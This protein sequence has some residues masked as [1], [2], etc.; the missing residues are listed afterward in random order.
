MIPRRRKILAGLV[1]LAVA[2][3]LVCL[4]QTRHALAEL[5]GESEQAATALRA[6]EH[7]RNALREKAGRRAP[8]ST[9][10]T[11]SAAGSKYQQWREALARIRRELPDG[12]PPVPPQ[13]APLNNNS[14]IFA[15]LLT[16]PEYERLALAYTRAT[17]ENS[18]ARYFAT[19]TAPAATVARLKEILVLREL[20]EREQKVI[21][22]KS[23]LPGSQSGELSYMLQEAHE[24]E[25]RKLL[26]EAEYA[27]FKHERTVQQTTVDAFSVRMSYAEEPLRP[28]QVKELFA[29]ITSE[30]E[31][32]SYG[33]QG[34]RTRMVPV[35]KFNEAALE[36]A[37]T[38]LTPAQWDQ[39]KHFQQERDA[40]GFQW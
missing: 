28:E 1:V 23:N 2:T 4:Q 30:Q 27:A 19:T 10:S 3:L 31:A 21:A 15:E 22:A 14:M 40:S 39:L 26:G 8:A 36:R 35:R 5:R 18:Y 17:I 37:R 24:A 11:R 9:E 13:S 32:Q 33:K 29:I 20:T 25:L 16:D 12:P 34:G 6:L 7:E 38:V